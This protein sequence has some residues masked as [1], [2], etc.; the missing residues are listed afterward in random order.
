MEVKARFGLANA[1]NTYLRL[2]KKARPGFCGILTRSFH[3]IIC[4]YYFRF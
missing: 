3:T 4:V 1:I 2:Q